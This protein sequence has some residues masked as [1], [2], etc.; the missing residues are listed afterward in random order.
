[1]LESVLTIPFWLELAACLTGSISGSMSAVRARYDLFGT[2]CLAVIVGLFGGVLRDILL[3]SFGIYAFQRPIVIIICVISGIVVF[4]F[5]Q[6]VGRLNTL[7]DPVFDFVDSL[8]V[9]LWA[10]ISV[11][12]GLSAGLDIVPSIILGTITAVG[13]GITRDIILN[14]P[15]ATFQ[16]GSLYGSASLV[17]S[18]LFAFMKTNHILDAQ[19]AFLCVGFILALRYISEILDWHTTPPRD[20]SERITQIVARPARAIVAKSKPT[21]EIKAMSIVRA[22]PVTRLDRTADI[23]APLELYIKPKPRSTKHRHRS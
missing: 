4:F 8:T 10:I 3:Q 1:M 16:A 18:I 13:G 19:S 12:K 9:G 15:I 20:Y 11:G 5:S 2:I 23:G 6:L 14:Q 17:G 22:R 7:L 21:R